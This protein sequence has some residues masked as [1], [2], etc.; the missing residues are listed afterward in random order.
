MKDLNLEY[1]SRIGLRI[2][3]LEDEEGNLRVTAGEART[4]VAA[5]EPRL[6]DDERALD[7]AIRQHY[8]RHGEML[9]AAEEFRQAILPELPV[10]GTRLNAYQWARFIRDVDIRDRASTV[11]RAAIVQGI[12]DRI[13]EGEELIKFNSGPVYPTA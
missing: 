7:A 6:T 12:L 3:E 11:V 8:E 5:L 9:T 1:A 4:W 2:P 10:W 13:A